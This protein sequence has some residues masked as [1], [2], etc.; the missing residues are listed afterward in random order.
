VLV[1]PIYMLTTRTSSPFIPKSVF[2]GY[3]SLPKGYKCLDHESGRVYISCDVIFDEHVFL[4]HRDSP[5]SDLPS[6]PNLRNMHPDNSSINLGHDHML[7]RLHANPLVAENLAPV[8]CSGS[9]PGQQQ[10]QPLISESAASAL[11]LR[12]R[13]LLW[14][15]LVSMRRHL[16]WRV[17]RNLRL[18]LVRPDL[19]ANLC[20]SPMTMIHLRQLLIHMI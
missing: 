8:S 13:Q 6:H 14:N 16:Q 18:L 19:L 20:M 15:P 11:L 5:H 10:Q 7:V 9:A 4:F 2:L 12:Q 3:S 17:A 1:G